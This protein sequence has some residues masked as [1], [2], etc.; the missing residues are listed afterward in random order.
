MV[1]ACIPISLQSFDTSTM[2]NGP[3][4]SLLP[5][6]SLDPALHAFEMDV[7]LGVRVVLQRPRK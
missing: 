5:E 1:S 3:A 6:V 2:A 4:I 7:G